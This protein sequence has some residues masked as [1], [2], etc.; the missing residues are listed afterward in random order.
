MIIDYIGLGMWDSIL[1]GS[2]L[3]SASDT[4]ITVFTRPSCQFW[5]S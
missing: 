2:R 1:L 5:D 3:D 4:M